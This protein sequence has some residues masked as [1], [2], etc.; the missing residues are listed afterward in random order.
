M[1]PFF[2]PMKVDDV[3][4]A[5]YA[6]FDNSRGIRL[7]IFSMT[8][9]WYARTSQP[10]A[11]PP[12][13]VSS[14]FSRVWI[15]AANPRRVRS[16]KSICP[17]LVGHWRT[18]KGSITSPAKSQ[19]WSIPLKYIPYSSTHPRGLQEIINDRQHRSGGPIGEVD[20]L[21]QPEDAHRHGHRPLPS[22]DVGCWD[23]GVL[24]WKGSRSAKAAN[25]CNYVTCHHMKSLSFWSSIR[26]L[27][28]FI[29]MKFH[30]SESSIHLQN[31]YIN[32]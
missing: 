3:P 24:G 18:H 12:R 1:E 27:L 21:P 11:P 8:G 19:S 13:V 6:K 28:K 16:W 32:K 29:L 15:A 2:W 23:A 26:E 30:S 25:V 22:E 4:T 10:G 5:F 7:Y 14:L 9:F 31:W 20:V 17:R